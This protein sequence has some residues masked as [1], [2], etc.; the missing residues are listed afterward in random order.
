MGSRSQR[1]FAGDY[2]PQARLD[3]PGR[4]GG[5]SLARPIQGYA[6]SL[7][8]RRRRLVSSAC[9]RY[10]F[11]RLVGKPRGYRAWQRR[12]LHVRRRNRNIDFDVRGR[13]FRWRRW[14][15]YVWLR[16]WD[17]ILRHCRYPSLQD[18]EEMRAKTLLFPSKRV[19]VHGSGNFF[20]IDAGRD[21][22]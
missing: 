12:A 13:R 21:L 6:V 8:L 17:R 4:G 22:L 16:R 18:R 9:R 15:D 19:F 20:A 7:N 14:S 5:L 10:F 1:R 3:A 11:W 2:P